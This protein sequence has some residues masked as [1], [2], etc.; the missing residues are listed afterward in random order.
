[1]FE[2]LVS[3]IL[4]IVV[5]KIIVDRLSVSKQLPPG[6]FPLPIIG[7]AHQ[8]SADS[9]HVDFTA[10]EK[11]YGRLFRLYLGSQLA[12]VVS[13]QAVIKEVLVTKSAEFA[14]R[15]SAYTM[16]VYSHGGRAIACADYSTEWRLHP[17]PQ[18]A[19]Y[20]RAKAGVNYH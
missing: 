6:P 5:V 7:N 9:R 11:Q 18:N 15:P 4:A 13:G 20:W 14:G 3:F 12:I 1:M 8:L 17:C 10:M 2:E 16:D 19:H